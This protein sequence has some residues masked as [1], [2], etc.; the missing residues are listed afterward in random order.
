MEKVVLI[1]IGVGLVVMGI[2]IASA[3][4]QPGTGTNAADISISINHPNYN[5]TSSEGLAA[6]NVPTHARV[7]SV[8]Q[9][10][11]VQ[12]NWRRYNNTLGE[13]FT[14]V[15]PFPG[16]TVKVSKY[17]VACGTNGKAAIK[18]V[19]VRTF[20]PGPGGE[21]CC[22]EPCNET[23]SCNSKLQDMSVAE[24]LDD[25]AA[26]DDA[27]EDAYAE[28]SI[29]FEE[30]EEITEYLEH[31]TGWIYVAQDNFAC[32]D[33][34]GL[35]TVC[36]QVFDHTGNYSYNTST[37]EYLSSVA[38]RVDFSAINYG[39]VNR[40]ETKWVDGDDDMATPGMPTIMNE[41][42]EPIALCIESWNMTAA[43]GGLIPAD[44]LD[45][46]IKGVEQWLTLSP[47]VLFDI[48]LKGG[49][50]TPINFSLHVPN[51]TPGG[52]YSGFIR[53]TGQLRP[54]GGLGVA[55]LPRFSNVTA[56]TTVNLSIKI[57]STENFDDLFHVHLTNNSDLP[58]DWQADMAWFNWTSTYVAI[59]GRGE[60]VIPLRAEIPAGVS[61]HK[62]FRAVAKSTKWTPVA[63]D[64]GIFSIA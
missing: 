14:Q 53:L 7:V 3:N 8:K 27:V 39:I 38:L 5:Y 46:K 28:G 52:N 64:S 50:P 22:G 34:A 18:E 29:T 32:S 33:P 30:K 47:G 11:K 10:P 15:Y 56:G 24:P 45:A 61:G 55:V 44:K 57:V 49:I 40:S 17:A 60:A 4:P 1:L 36:T 42:N 20:Y 58:P 21:S 41:G 62:A 43:T 48:N 31:G 59:P 37:I 13:V 25:R 26:C 9:Q 23:C 6:V 35:Y 63:Y 51:E 2:A 12:Y 16:Q 19:V 54:E